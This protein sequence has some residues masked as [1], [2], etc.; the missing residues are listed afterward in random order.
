M[1]QSVGVGTATTDTTLQS[2]V[3]VLA[4]VHKKNI[5]FIFNC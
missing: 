4:D 1:K 2:H 5:R 3:P